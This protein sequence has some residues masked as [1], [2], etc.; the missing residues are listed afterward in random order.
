MKKEYEDEEIEEVSKQYEKFEEE[1]SKKRG[2]I[3][4]DPMHNIKF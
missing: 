2:T 1:G 3:F 4:G